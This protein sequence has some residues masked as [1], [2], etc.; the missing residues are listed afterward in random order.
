MMIIDK[1]IEKYCINYKS[2][3]SQALKKLNSNNSKIV[4]VTDNNNKLKGSL[5]ANV[6]IKANAEDIV[7]LDKLRE[8]LHFVFISSKASVEQGKDFVVNIEQIEEE[9][10]SRC[11]HRDAS[12]GKSKAHPGIC[13]RCEENIVSTGEIRSFV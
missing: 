13:S 5:D 6:R 9:K 10:C 11:W 8:E 3:V 7:I 1:N 4:F 2:T 12:V